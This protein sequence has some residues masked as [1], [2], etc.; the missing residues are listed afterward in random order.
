MSSLADLAA[1]LPDYTPE[2]GQSLGAVALAAW[3]EG[4]TVQQWLD[5]DAE[6][7]RRFQERNDLP[8]ALIQLALGWFIKVNA[9]HMP[10]GSA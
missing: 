9:G 4:L 7:M 2:I 10:A 5:L 1:R 6:G 8:D 3:I